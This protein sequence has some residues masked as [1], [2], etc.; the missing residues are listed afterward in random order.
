L[1]II[2]S[3]SFSFFSCLLIFL[4]AFSSRGRGLRR[5]SS[6]PQY[7]FV[8]LLLSLQH[9][10]FL[11]LTHQFSSPKWL[12]L[13]AKG[14]NQVL[15]PSEETQFHAALSFVYPVVS[16]VFAIFAKERTQLRSKGKPARAFGNTIKPTTFLRAIAGIGRWFQESSSSIDLSESAIL[17]FGCACWA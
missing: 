2:D 13:S 16:T 6:P 5:G 14:F 1:V 12:L 4:R 8:E 15:Y 9:F 7:L 3:N 17:L 11:R 10:V